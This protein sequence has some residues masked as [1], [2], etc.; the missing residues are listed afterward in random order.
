MN[1]EP[2]SVLLLL[3]LEFNEVL[4]LLIWEYLWTANWEF[5]DVLFHWEYI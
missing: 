2:L 4:S 3:Y 1:N 5:N